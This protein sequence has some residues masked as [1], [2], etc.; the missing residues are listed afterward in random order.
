MKKKMIML[1]IL[2]IIIMVIA[3]LILTSTF[4]KSELDGD[5][6]RNLKGVATAVLAAYDQNDGEYNV[7]GKSIWK[8][9][10]NISKSEG[11]LDPIKENSGIDISFY[12]G[13]SIVVTTVTDASGER[14][15]GEEV[16]NSIAKKVIEE[17]ETVF[18]D[19]IRIGAIDYYGYYMP[20]YQSTSKKKTPKASNVSEKAKEDGKDGEV[21]EE[22]S[23]EPTEEIVN[24]EEGEVIGIIFAG[25]PKKE[26]DKTYKEIL[27]IL[28]IT[29]LLSILV[30]SVFAAMYATSINNSI[31]A[32][33]N[34]VKE[35]A[36]GELTAEVSAKYLNQ[37]DEIGE[38]CR[39]IESM[40]NE[41]RFV[42]EDIDGNTQKLLNSADSL[43]SNA[44]STLSTVD[45]VDRAVNEI[46]DGATSQ[47]K[48]AARATQNV[49]VMGDVLVATNQEIDNLDNNALI[50]KNSSEQATRSLDELMKINQEVTNAIQMIYEQ[51][52]RTNA[53]SQKIKEATSLISNISDETNLLSLNASIEAARAGEQ[54]R[55]FAVVANEIQHLAEQSGTSTDAIA[56]MVNELISDSDKAVDTMKKVNEII[57]EQSKNVEQTQAVVQGVIRAIEES[58]SSIVSIKQQ[59]THLNKVK[60]EIV[61]VVESL[62]AIA[63]ENAAS[64]E[65]TSAATAEVANSFNEVTQAADSLKVIADSI[66]GTIGT[67]KLN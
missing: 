41:L 1:S 36:A 38:L 20:V 64:T 8:G 46:A 29:G 9:I 30:F 15:V 37:Q 14:L 66:A 61:E 5:V 48:D 7:I 60:D 18:S 10:Y 28:Q 40:K 3:I 57:L 49:L 2:P 50:M 63:E 22:I 13:T 58:L 67:F 11:M 25:A 65:Q 59:S 35:V 16:D 42:I 17:K 33:E 43:D 23:K 19:G 55:G 26:Q 34:A 44:Q 31:A 27:R 21:P 56:A 45:S 53:S 6:E 47:A 62:S 32:A 39:A 12:Y 52:N 51:T 4:V 54:G 24:P